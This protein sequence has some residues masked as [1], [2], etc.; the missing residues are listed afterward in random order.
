[1]DDS[2]LPAE[3]QGKS[4]GLTWSED[5]RPSGAQ[6]AFVIHSVWTLERP[7]RDDSTIN[8]VIIIFR[9]LDKYNPEG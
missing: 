4:V 8:I 6:S 7:P 3:W 2:S 5:W 9:T 1:M